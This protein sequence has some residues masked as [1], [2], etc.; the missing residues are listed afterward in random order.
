LV[1]DEEF[2]LSN[3]NFTDIHMPNEENFI[4]DDRMEEAHNKQ[5]GNPCMSD[6]KPDKVE[7]TMRAAILDV[8]PDDG[9]DENAG[10]GSV[11]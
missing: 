2:E 7:I 5:K 3:E 9:G 8:T 10:K 6:C 4:P 11:D 1:D